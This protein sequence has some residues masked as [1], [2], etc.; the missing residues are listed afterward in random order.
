VNILTLMVDSAEIEASKKMKYA[1]LR[2]DLL[3]AQIDKAEALTGKH[4]KYKC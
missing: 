4:F 3:Q 2:R 1:Q